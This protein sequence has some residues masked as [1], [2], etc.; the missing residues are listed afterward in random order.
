MHIVACNNASYL[1]KIKKQKFMMT[2]EETLLIEE[3]CADI[4]NDNNQMEE[5]IL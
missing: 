3:Y 1:C 2:R 5:R 4:V